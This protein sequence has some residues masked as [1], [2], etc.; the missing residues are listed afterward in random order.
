MGKFICPRPEKWHEIYRI[1]AAA[2]KE[3]NDRG[4]E[5]VPEPLILSEW[6]HSDDWERELRWHEYLEWAEE[7]G[8]SN[9]IPRL[10]EEES[11]FG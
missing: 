6:A 11:H 10:E 8:F 4:I 5:K 3:R 7:Y 2:R 9:L 1:L